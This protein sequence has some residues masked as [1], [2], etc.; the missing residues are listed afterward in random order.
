MKF[1]KP[2]RSNAPLSELCWDH[3]D[4]VVYVHLGHHHDG[5]SLDPSI[6]LCHHPCFPVSTT[7]LQTS[8]YICR[9]CQWRCFDQYEGAENDVDSF[10]LYRTNCISQCLAPLPCHSP[11]GCVPIQ[12]TFLTV[13]YAL[14]ILPLLPSSSCLIRNCVRFPNLVGLSLTFVRD[15]SVTSSDPLTTASLTELNPCTVGL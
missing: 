13:A 4:N 3:D 12:T 6:K 8:L 15:S 14:P 5:A 7:D 2:S 10:D 9:W 11:T 1:G